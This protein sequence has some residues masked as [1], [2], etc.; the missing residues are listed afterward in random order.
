MKQSPARAAARPQVTPVARARI[1]SGTL[2]LAAAAMLAA[3]GGSREP[4]LPR[5]EVSVPW[6]IGGTQMVADLHMHTRFSDGALEI[7][8]LVRKSYAAGCRVVAIT[9]HSDKN[10]KAGTQEY[11]NVIANLRKRYPKHVLIGGLEWNVP[12]H[13]GRIHMGVLL[14]PLVEQHLISFKQ[15]FEDPQKSVGD[16]LGWLR[17]QIID[18]AHAALIYNHPSRHGEPAEQVMMEW[19]RMRAASTQVIGM[20]GG[21]GHQNMVPNGAY[22]LAPTIDRWDQAV[23]QVGGAWDMLLDRGESPWAAIANSDYHKTPSEFTPC[24]FSRTVLKVPEPTASGVLKALHAGSFWASQGRFIDYFLFT[25][26]APGLTLSASPGEVIRVQTG[27]ELYAR[28]AVERFIEAGAQPLTVEIIGNCATGKPETLAT[29][30]LEPKQTEVE[31]T[32]PADATGADGASCY[33]RA[34]VRGQNPKGEPAVAYINPVRI[35]LAQ[36]KR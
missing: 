11:L 8:D 32:I 28:V 29:L 31:A 18:P 14:D 27:S 21:P 30:R 6:G 33:L 16:G 23:A 34:R 22:T 10:T 20:E 36:V 35:R 5:H 4:P 26:G 24:E 19:S 1:A 7:E 12:P 2:A 25:V 13:L 3:C 9:D 17:Q 15:Q